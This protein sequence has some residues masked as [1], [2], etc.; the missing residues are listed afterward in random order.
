[1]GAAWSRLDSSKQG[2]PNAL[3]VELII[4]LFPNPKCFVVFVSSSLKIDVR[5]LRGHGIMQQMRMCSCWPC[6]F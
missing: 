1:M 2:V 4:L 5:G 3:N 6:D